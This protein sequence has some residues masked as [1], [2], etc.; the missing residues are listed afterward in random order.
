MRVILAIGLIGALA[1]Q[2]PADQQFSNGPAR[3]TLIELFTSEGCSSC[4]PA[5]QWLRTLR[6]KPGLWKDFVPVEFHVNFWDTRGW[7]DRFSTP[8]ITQREYDYATLWG[9]VPYTPCFARNG[10]LWKPSWGIVGGTGAPMGVL[11]VSVADNGTCT[12]E[13]KPGAAAR[14]PGD[15][16]F[17]VH[18]AL[19]GNGL[20]S[21][22]TDGENSGQVM[23]HDFVVLGLTS[24][25]LT[26]APGTA[27]VPL[28][29]KV[30][31]PHPLV[32]EGTR[33][34]LAAWVT[35]HGEMEPIQATGGWL[36]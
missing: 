27:P 36:F 33:H 20:I 28:Q 5:D 17:E 2:A 22:I 13:F 32:A 9:C 3:A 18:V 6:S 15:G 34:A 19:L 7:K 31:L 4:L 10:V 35:A 1:S 25:I 11:S 12:V 29:A 8:D 30:A 24:Q 14:L 26:P 21:N 23:Q 16:S